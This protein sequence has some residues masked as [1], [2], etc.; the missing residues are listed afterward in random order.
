MPDDS[1]DNIVITGAALATSLG[2]TREETWR[3][4]RAGRCGMTA[5]TALESPLPPEKLGGQAIDLPPDYRPDDP[6]EVRYL[7]WTIAAALRDANVAAKSPYPPHR[8]GVVLGTTLHGMRAGGE[9][10]RSGSYDPLR[11]FLA[12]HTLQRACAG[13]DLDGFAATTCSACS[14]SLGAIALGMTLLQAGEVDLVIAGGYDTISE[15]VYGGFNALR[16]VADGPLR[17][18]AKDRQGMKLAEGYGIVVLERA[19]DAKRRSAKPIATILGC[20]ESADAHHLTQ[21]HP[22]GDGAARAIAEALETAGLTATEID[23]VAAHATGTPDND[24]GE[25]AAFSR[26]FGE[27][28]KKTP[29][30]AFKSHLGH[31][32]GGAGAVELILSAM[33]IRDQVIPPCAND[34]EPEF[35]DLN[36]ARGT[37]RPAR[38]RAT[39]NTSL[40]FGGANT[41]AILAGPNAR[42]GGTPKPRKDNDVVITG[43]GV[44]VPGAASND[45]FIARLAQAHEPCWSADAGAIPESDYLHLLNARRVRRMSE[46]VKLSLAAT[47]LALKDAKLDESPDFGETTSV[48]LGSAH[49]SADFSST[50]Y[51]EIVKQGL[52]GANPVLFAE[53][54]PNSAAAHLSLM[55]DLKGGCQT[56]IGS[57]TSGLDALHLAALRIRSGQ[58]QRAIVGAGEEYNGIVNGAYGHCGLYAGANAAGAAPSKEK[59][60]VTGSAAVT[61]VLESR[62]AAIRRG[63][64]GR[65][66]VVRSASFRGRPNESVESACRVLETLRSPRAVL[67]S[68]SG[69]WVDRAEAA[70]LRRAAPSATASSLYGHVAEHFSASPLLAIAGT[71]LTG[72]LPRMLQPLRDIRG[73]D[74][75]EPADSFAA[76]CT[77]FTGCVSGVLVDAERSI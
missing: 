32:L 6:R 67:T 43:I 35:V 56:I 4:V 8:C 37:E 28:L 34:D 61:F 53:G 41:A 27:N 48:I 70:A 72:H 51:R 59:G 31:T 1:V 21:P 64:A 23:L 66:I 15:Y 11:S 47:A 33:A 7:S 77:D 62:E 54:V 50:Y 52:I 73:A 60:F 45:A 25:Y 13:F 68:A 24:A 69:T 5:L 2:V 10:L 26:V 3:A 16:L 30:V 65:G 39:L 40:G 46:Y 63:V 57:R 29:V 76:I 44:I 71:L 58:W 18:F 20:G 75:S 42:S 55:L 19:G 74:G 38:L 9:F 36:L 17:P 12:S 14:S 22:H 49:G